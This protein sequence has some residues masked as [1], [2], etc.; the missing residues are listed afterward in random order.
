MA[1]KSNTTINS[2]K[3]TFILALLNLISRTGTISIDGHDPK[4]LPPDL[5]RSRITTIPQDPAQLPGTVR[6]NLIP[7]DLVIR[8]ESMQMNDEEIVSILNSLF[9]WEHIRLNGGL[10]RHYNDMSFSHGQRQLVALAAA[11]IHNKLTETKLVIMDESTSHLDYNMD[12]KVQAYLVGA[13]GNS[14]VICVNH[15]DKGFPKPDITLA[16]NSGRLDDVVYH[17]ETVDGEAG[18]DQD[19]EEEEEDLEVGGVGGAEEP[20]DSGDTQRRDEQAGQ[21]LI[22]Q[23]QP[24]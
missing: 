6:D 4:Q 3:S 16:F 9:I 7:S 2:G 12:D 17:K 23:A 10:D 18:Q 19:Q 22:G 15:R 20:R 21:S 8:A 5:L 1:S 11:V 13:F 24:K 14:T